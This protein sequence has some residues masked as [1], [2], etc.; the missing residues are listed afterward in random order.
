MRQQHIKRA[1]VLAPSKSGIFF[2]SQTPR[3]A[4]PKETLLFCCWGWR[5]ACE[6]PRLPKLPSQISTLR[7]AN[8]G[9]KS[10]YVPRPR[11]DVGS[12][13][14]IPHRS[15]SSRHCA[16]TSF[17]AASAIWGTA[18]GC[19][20]YHGLNLRLPLVLSRK[21]CPYSLRLKRRSDSEG[22]RTDY[23]AADSLQAYV[24]GLYRAAGTNGT[25]HSGRRTF[26]T[27][28]LRNG[29]TI[30]QV[31]LLLGHESIDH[32]N[33]YIDVSDAEISRAFRDVI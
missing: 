2:A 27:R 23:W 8:C 32:T 4:I 24:T 7:A 13:V 31:Q 17:I 19:A 16:D 5:A 1:E 9:A 6:S 26:A 21:G 15:N 12:D 20:H 3:V 10:R 11:R 22:R 30:E 29:V 18:L 28:L 25:S 33:R 14:S